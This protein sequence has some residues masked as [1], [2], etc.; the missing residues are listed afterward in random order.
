MKIKIPD[1]AKQIYSEDVLNVFENNYPIIGTLWVKHQMDW[2]NR[3][4]SMFKDHTKGMIVIYLIRKTLDFY[5]KNFI[6]LSYEQ[7]YSK[8][9][10]A[11]G[12]FNTIEISKNL[13]IPK[14]SARRK[15]FELENQGVIKRDRENIIIDRSTFPFIKP[16]DSINRIS[17]FLSVFSEKLV[18]EKI[19]PNSLTSKALIKILEKNFTHIWKLFYDMQISMMLSYKKFFID[20]ETWHIFGT[21]VVNQHLY[22]KTLN[23]IKMNRI[24]FINSFILNNDM[25]GINAMS[26]SDITGIPRATVVR[27][28]QKLLKLNF[29][30]ID[31]K[32]HYILSGFL[33][34]KVIP[35]QN[36][37]LKQLTN[38]S[39]KVYNLA[40]L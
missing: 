39:T 25:T 12:K 5:S 21:C 31:K 16:D 8:T 30:L 37:V 11:L 26:I 36:I 10:V 6:K 38:F 3:V 2:S 22:P 13:A 9:S 23:K 32:K 7:Y 14:E 19:L 33:V 17:I 34:K 28:L 29:L 18:Q 4:Y 35:L 27:K 24:E 40:L 15:L 20:L 1:I